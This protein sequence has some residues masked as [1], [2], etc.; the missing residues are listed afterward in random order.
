MLGGGCGRAWRA[1]LAAAG[2][3]SA[4]L[5]LP[6]AAQA[7][8]EVEV[9]GVSG[10]MKAN[11]EAY[12]SIRDAANQKDLDQATV[13]RLQRQAGPELREALRPFGYYNPFIDARLE[14]AAPKWKA[15]YIIHPGPRTVWKRVDIQISGEGA[16]DFE[17]ELARMHH[18]LQEGEG[19]LHSDYDE[20]KAIL[21][22][23]AYAR[24]Y[25]DAQYVEA[26]LR[27]TPADNSAEA[28]LHFDTGSRYRF[29][30]FS[31]EQT[32]E[33]PLEDA[34]LRRYVKIHAGAEYDPQ[35]LLDTQFALSD[36]GY[37][38]SV[39]MLPQREQAQ[40]HQVPIL[41]RTTPRKS[42]RYDFGIGYGTDTGVRG[43]VASDFRHLN[44]TGHS[45]HVETQVSHIKNT[46]AGEY[47]IPRGDKPGEMFTLNGVLGQQDYSAGLSRFYG[48]GAGLART[49]GKWQRR[50]YL[51]YLHEDSTLGEDVTTADMLM[52]GLT[53]NRAALDDA[54]YTRRGW[55][56]FF[57]V[58]G[59]VKDAMS[60]VS[61]T[62]AHLIVKGAYPLWQR[63]RLLARYETGA[64]LV[65][66]FSRLPASQRFFAGGDQSVRGYDYQ[67]I[68]PRDANGAVVGGNFLTT[69]SLE[70]ETRVYG[71]W[72]AASFY[73]AGGVENH[74]SPKL[75]QGIGVGLRYRAPI[76]SV[77]IDLAH[78]VEDNG[79]RLHIGVR[80]GL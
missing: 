30:E 34:F 78:P 58:H 26:E 13:D 60:S 21:S 19:I 25:L 50:Y 46:A 8:I 20:A 52:P 44:D 57:D 64:N 10:A 36:L 9:S 59:A 35:K 67:S 27:V 18:R 54:I 77:Q 73:D 62:Q 42:Q 65:D 51:K 12:L 55:S 80:V 74:V 4:A 79:V 6:A 38:Q 63:T 11:A 14:G 32:G 40:D 56:L 69:M 70:L 33:R 5:L 68:G 16:A 29:G 41:I 17:K 75:K 45:L 22:S 23:A 48:F 72:G 7:N 61:F 15:Q 28:V 39:E 3:L 53:L 71:N 43:S 49:P 24:G 2:L 76:G 47:R 66:Q 37:F 31:I 1:W